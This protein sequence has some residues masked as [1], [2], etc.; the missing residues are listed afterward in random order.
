MTIGLKIIVAAVNLVCLIVT[1]IYPNDATPI[2]LLPCWITAGTWL[3]NRLSSFTEKKTKEIVLIL[4]LVV[5]TACAAFSLVIGFACDYT[6]SESIDYPCYV[7]KETAI[8]PFDIQLNYGIFQGFVFIVCLVYS[9]LE[10]VFDFISNSGDEKK[11][12]S[13]KSQK[14]PEEL[15]GALD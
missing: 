15:V 5:L 13:K 12:V 9:I 11:A 2:S 8:I 4:P 6:I 14:T 1:L 7:A 10:I 3:Y